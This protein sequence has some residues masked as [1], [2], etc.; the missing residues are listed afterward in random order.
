MNRLV[1]LIPVSVLRDEFR[2]QPSNV[3]VAQGETAILECSPPRGHPEPA[4][5]WKKNGQVID[6]ENNQR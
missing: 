2:I 5:L 3:R 1:T 6:L 4:V